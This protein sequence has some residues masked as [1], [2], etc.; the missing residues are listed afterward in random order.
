VEVG[1]E[2]LVGSVFVEYLMAVFTQLCAE[3]VLA[4]PKPWSHDN[5]KSPFRVPHYPLAN[6]RYPV[7]LWERTVCG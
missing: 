1:I 6:E 2:F 5:T 7:I 3:F 4:L